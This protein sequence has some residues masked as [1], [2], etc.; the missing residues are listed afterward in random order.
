MA[1]NVHTMEEVDNRVWLMGM[2]L[3]GGIAPVAHAPNITSNM[4][5]VDMLTEWGFRSTSS[6]DKRYSNVNEIV[7]Y[8]NWRGP[9]WT[10]ANAILLYGC[11]QY[12]ACKPYAVG[13]AQEMVHALADDLR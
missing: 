8:S 1:R 3:W 13:I 12:E 7:P 6:L 11:M 4:I 2:P 10:N 5:A 9:V